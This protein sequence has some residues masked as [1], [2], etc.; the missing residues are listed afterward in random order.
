MG[1]SPRKCLI[2]IHASQKQQQES[3]IE[4]KNGVRG[5]GFTLFPLPFL[6]P[7]ATEA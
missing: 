4:A 7:G 3:G 5:A 6:E 2:A 1:E